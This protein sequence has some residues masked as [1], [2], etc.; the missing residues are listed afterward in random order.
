MFMKASH[1]IEYIVAFCV[2]VR[3]RYPFKF[4]KKLITIYDRERER[5]YNK[6]EYI[7]S[8]TRRPILTSGMHVVTKPLTSAVFEHMS[9]QTRTSICHL[10][11]TQLVDTRWEVERE[12]NETPEEHDSWL[13][14]AQLAVIKD[15]TMMPESH[16]A[17]ITL[18]P[19]YIFE[20]IWYRWPDS[21][22][23]G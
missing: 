13:K 21:L 4:H 10:G 22:D 19:A 17:Q 23:N 9:F 16:A 11:P 3:D 7:L 14:D 5:E 8:S 6:I 2:R 15:P 20:Y 1:Y 18:S 12:T